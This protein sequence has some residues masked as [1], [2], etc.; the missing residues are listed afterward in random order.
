MP[1]HDLLQK[2]QDLSVLAVPVVLAITSHEAAHGIVAYWLGDDTAYRQ[3]RVSLNPARHI[4]PFGTIVLPILL[5]L[6]GGFLFGFA[7]P[8]PT[9][10]SRMRSPRRDMVLVAL[11]G[12]GMNIGLAVVSALLFHLVNSLP[13][14]AQLWVFKVLQTSIQINLI[15]AVF[16]MLPL[17]P[18]DG[19][20]VITSVLPRPLAMRYVSFGRYGILVV[21][22]LFFI[23]PEL[24]VRLG[25]DFDPFGW[26]IGGPAE[27]LWGLILRMVGL[28]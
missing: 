8:V 23:L 16:N 2:L 15:L 25:I 10:A 1:E 20:H 4:D 11:A 24:A 28:P 5:Y 19:S 13:T 6:T 12:P 14:V 22:A 18:L 17:P 9:N 7:K 27:W 21:L 3:G 26:L